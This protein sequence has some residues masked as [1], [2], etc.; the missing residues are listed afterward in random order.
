MQVGCTLRAV[1]CAGGPTVFRTLLATRFAP[2]TTTTQQHTAQGTQH[3]PRSTPP[4]SRSSTQHAPHSTRRTAHST[5]HTAHS[6]PPR[7]HHH[8]TRA[9]PHSSQHHSQE[10]VFSA[11]SREGFFSIGE[12]DVFSQLGKRL[13]RQSPLHLCCGAFILQLGDT[14]STFDS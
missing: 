6:T 14:L 1:D 5:Q 13:C 10:K 12:C 9:G 4:P 7:H 11:Q 8:V 3:T 2:T